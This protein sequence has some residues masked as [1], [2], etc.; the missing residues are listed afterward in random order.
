MP[1][2]YACVT[3]RVSLGSWHSCVPIALSPITQ[4]RGKKTRAGNSSLFWSSWLNILPSRNGRA[5]FL[6]SLRPLVELGYCQG[7]E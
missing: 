7:H 5:G 2:T 3:H 6:R 4:K 1:P